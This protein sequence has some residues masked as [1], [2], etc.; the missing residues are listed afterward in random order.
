M[1]RDVPNR[2]VPNRDVLVPK[3]LLPNIEFPRVKW[4]NRD[5]ENREPLTAEFPNRA[6]PNA[7][8]PLRAA[9][10]DSA[11][12][13]EIVEFRPLPEVAPSERVPDEKPDETEELPRTVEAPPNEFQPVELVAEP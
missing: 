4:L 12:D 9:K 11:R 7:D 1:N 13:E 10:F 8:A 6:P 5:P 2:D 3:R